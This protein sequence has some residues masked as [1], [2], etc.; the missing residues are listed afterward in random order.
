MSQQTQASLALDEL[1][2]AY[3]KYYDIIYQSTDALYKIGM[4]ITEC[5]CPI[6]ALIVE[7]LENKYGAPR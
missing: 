3:K 7:D 5:N 1:E 4:R 6:R 2:K